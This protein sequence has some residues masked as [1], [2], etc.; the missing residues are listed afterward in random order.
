LDALMGG[1]ERD[2]V[3]LVHWRQHGKLYI[4]ALGILTLASE[5]F[6]VGARGLRQRS[7]VAWP[8]SKHVRGQQ[9]DGLHGQAMIDR[10]LLDL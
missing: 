7:K 5:P 9:R 1:S 2:A 8:W 6:G 10:R 3:S 4:G